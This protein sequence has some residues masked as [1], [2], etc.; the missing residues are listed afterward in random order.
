[1][2]RARRSRGHFLGVEALMKRIGLIEAPA[3]PR[4][5][6]R[7]AGGQLASDSGREDEHGP[8]PPAPPQFSAFRRACKEAQ[9]EWDNIQVET[10]IRAIGEGIRN[11]VDKISTPGGGIPATNGYEKKKVIRKLMSADPHMWNAADWGASRRRDLQAWS[12]ET[13]VLAHF[14]DTATAEYI[15]LFMFGRLDRG[16]LACGSRRGHS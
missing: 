15:S 12:L 9:A 2:K 1:M 6:K 13:K 11:V 16:M 5:R 3:M 14:P 7:K 10:S 4:G 8:P